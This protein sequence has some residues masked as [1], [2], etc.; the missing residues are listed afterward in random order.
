MNFRPRFLALGTAGWMLLA[1]FPLRAEEHWPRFRG[2]LGT[3]HSTE[4]GLPTN[5]TPED[6]AW[7]IALPGRGQSSPVNWGGTLFLTS[8]E[9]SGATRQIFAI[10]ASDGNLLWTRKVTVSQPEA[11]H[12]MNS[13]ATPT[14]ATDGEVV[15]AFFG[16][17]GLHAWD[18]QGNP[19]WSRADLGTFPGDWGIGASPILDG[20]LVIQ[21]CDAE[22]PSYLLAVHRRTGETVWKTPRRDSPKGGWS[23]PILID[24]PEPKRRELVLNGEFGVQAYDPATGRE[25]WFCAAPTGR[26]EPVPEYAHGLLHVLCGKPGNTYV[27]RP[28]GDGDVSATHLVRSMR[29]QGGRDLPSPAVVGNVF[30]A[31]SMSGIASCYDAT[32]GDLLGEPVR[33]DAAVSGSPLV[34]GGLVYLLAESGEVLVLRPGNPLQ[35][36]SRNRLGTQEGEIFRSSPAPIGG[37]LYFRSDR[38]LYRVGKN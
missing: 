9:E 15:V 20:D 8:A 23:T 6:V 37:A 16:P 12:Q 19:L 2:P 26:G 4:A 29:R 17:G 34:A 24:V 30:F 5:W 7:R 21:N 36:V 38:A 35:I 1:S 25:L 14:C 28:G 18:L 3:G 32:T 11:I 10:R 31:C 22:G 13:H 33:L 27:V